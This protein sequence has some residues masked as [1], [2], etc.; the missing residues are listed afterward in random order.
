M[1]RVAGVY[2][3]ELCYQVL[4]RG[5]NRQPIFQPIFHDDADRDY[6]TTLVAEY[7]E[8]IMDE[9]GRSR[10]PTHCQTVAR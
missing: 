2:Q 8:L 9:R 7:K 10:Y 1:P 4:N 5:V 3:P 6:F